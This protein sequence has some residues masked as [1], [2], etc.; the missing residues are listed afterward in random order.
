MKHA[1]HWDTISLPS[2]SSYTP[3]SSTTPAATADT[4]T[5]PLTAVSRRT[6]DVTATD[7]ARTGI[8]HSADGGCTWHSVFSLSQVTGNDGT[9]LT[10]LDYQFSSLVA[11]DGSGSRP[12]LYAAAVPH[13]GNG[14]TASTLTYYGTFG[15]GPNVTL[16]LFT[17]VS[18]DGGATWKQT[19]TDSSL[20][21]IQNDALHPACM[22][23]SLA[24]ES[25]RP[26][27]VSIHCQRSP[28]DGTSALYTSSDSGAHWTAPAAKNIPSS[29]YMPALGFGSGLGNGSTLWIPGN[30]SVP[31]NKDMKTFV[32]VYRST[33]HGASW[34][35]VALR[36][37]KVCDVNTTG[38]LVSTAT[39]PPR[40]KT[41]AMWSPAAFMRSTN[42]GATW[43]RAVP[44]VGGTGDPDYEGAAIT[45]PSDN[46]TYVVAGWPHR[47]DDWGTNFRPWSLDL[48][49]GHALLTLDRRGRWQ[50]V[51]AVPAPN[52]TALYEVQAGW[53]YG[54]AV[55]GLAITQ[56]S[57]AKTAFTATL[58]R[59]RS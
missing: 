50:T 25:D 16:R 15:A 30:I 22:N 7:A 46:T 38:W 24:V 19:N 49:T 57:T 23:G 26:A 21:D 12:T 4:H 43:T 8:W 20:S 27:T 36:A 41:I 53:W 54:S 52:N 48:R 44:F 11:G 51:S 6:G 33:D 45:G 3:A 34:Q 18:R 56:N 59:Y 32:T 5:Y 29:P 13:S 1:G 42:G 10:D 35:S 58:L 55:Y 31:Q 2:S 14:Q 28:G 40:G 47:A 39:S 9:W 37:D 17:F